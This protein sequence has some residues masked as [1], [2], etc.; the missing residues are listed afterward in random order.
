MNR[1]AMCYCHAEDR[2]ALDLL[3]LVAV[4]SRKGGVDA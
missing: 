4:G 3:E 1:L 2:I